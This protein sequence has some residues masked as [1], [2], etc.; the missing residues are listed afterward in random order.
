MKTARIPAVYEDGVLKPLVPL[1]LPEHQTIYI[2]IE[3]RQAQSADDAL[4]AWQAIYADFGDE[5]IAELEAI[6]LNCHS[7]MRQDVQ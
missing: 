5:E 7:F 3:T 1:D 6:V 4:R 2:T